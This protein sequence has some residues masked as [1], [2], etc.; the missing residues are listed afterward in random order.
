M[1]IQEAVDPR[2]DRRYR[3]LGALYRIAT[4][5]ISHGQPDVVIDELLAVVED[6]LEARQAFLFLYDED[7]ERLE[8][9]KRFSESGVSAPF[10]EMA[11]LRRMMESRT[12]EIVNDLAADPDASITLTDMLQAR[13]LIGAPLA[14]GEDCLGVLAAVDC[15]RGA[16]GEADIRLLTILADRAALTLE[17]SDLIKTLRRQVQ[18][19]EGLQRL[20]KL[21]ATSDSLESTIGEANRIIQDLIGCEKMAFLLHEEETNELVGQSP[22]IGIDADVLKRLRIPLGEPSLAGTVFRTNTPLISND[23]ATDGWIHPKFRELLQI[24]NIMAVPLSTGPRPV[25]VLKAINASKG[26]FDELDLRF[27]TLL[28]SRVTSVLESTRSRDR[29]RALVRQLREADRTK[30]EFVSML[31]HELKGPM[32]TVMG[33]GETLIT[34]ADK[35]K[36]EKRTQI[37]EI[38]TKEVGRLARLVNDLLD[39]SRMDAG[40]LRYDLEPMSLNEVVESILQVH[41]SL[42][43][44]HFVESQV[45]PDLP[46]VMGD[47]DRVRQVLI[48]LLTNATR[49]SPG[50]TT[51]TVTAEPTEDNGRQVVR[52][53]VKD[54]G[55]GISPDDRDR[56]F[57]KFAMLPKPAW[58]KKGTGL[59]LFITQGIVEAHGGRIWLESEL[60]KGTTFFFT[61]P[62]AD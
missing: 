28:G 15:K 39:V 24:E 10:P 56:I 52:V 34:Q 62:I 43:V 37:V 17:N 7:T 25:G 45:P 18:E 44:D 41:T 5:N 59:G 27:M 23:A 55:I 46:K 53:G 61:L 30:S 33:F 16:F 32:T 48:N 8:M 2:D 12:P 42:R 36:E 11:T 1:G 20:T 22:A 38:I 50:E 13:Q 60:G 29:E 57:T 47:R 21:L 40:T 19:L 58:V 51:I 54:E 6:M 3:E 26:H 4:L 31:A 14:V 35:I 49:Y 9:R